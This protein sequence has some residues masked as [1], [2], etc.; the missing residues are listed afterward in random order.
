M[1]LYQAEK[2]AQAFLALI[3]PACERAE[4]AGSIRRRQPTVNDAELVVIPKTEPAL[5][6]FDTGERRSL[7]E[8]LL[9]S[10]STDRVRYDEQ[11]KRNGPR[12]KRFVMRGLPVD[13][14]IVTPPAQFGAILALRTGPAEYSRWL[15][16]AQ[17][18]GGAMPPGH[19]LAGGALRRHGKLIPTPEETDLFREIG[20]KWIAPEYRMH[21]APFAK[22]P[23]GQRV[24]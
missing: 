9:Q 5:T 7:L 19:E 21:Y 4:I 22:D 6:L 10:L 15:V 20:G 3:A 2:V 12:Y 11:T 23:H 16:T 17:E 18:A 24:H 14:F 1:N 13:L 8:P